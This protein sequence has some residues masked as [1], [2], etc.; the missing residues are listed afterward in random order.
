M[1]PLTK[2]G[3][4][5]KEYFCLNDKSLI[6]IHNGILDNDDKM[7]LINQNGSFNHHNLGIGNIN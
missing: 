1:V 7:V 4:R 2:G 5:S 6:D 3:A